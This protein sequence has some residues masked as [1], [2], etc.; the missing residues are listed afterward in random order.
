MIEWLLL[1]CSLPSDG[2]LYQQ[3]LHEKDFDRA[4]GLCMKITEDQARGDCAVA[5]MEALHRRDPADCQRLEPGIWKEECMFLYAERAASDGHLREAFQSCNQTRFGRE[6]SYHLIRQ[7]VRSVLA[8][9]PAEAGNLLLAYQDLPWAPD[10]EW[11]F[12]KTYW[13]QRL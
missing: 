5:V 13:R 9:P 6:C 1:A 10:A 8:L 7:G 2:T 12:W 3:A 11:L 4:F